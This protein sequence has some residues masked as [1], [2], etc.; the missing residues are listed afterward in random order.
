[1]I[2]HNK[3]LLLG[4]SDGYKEVAKSLHERNE[5]YNKAK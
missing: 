4:I 1:M 2:V 3:V 5:T